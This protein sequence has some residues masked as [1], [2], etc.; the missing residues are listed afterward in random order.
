MPTIKQKKAFKKIIENHGSVSAAM[1]EVGY[2]EASAKNPSNLTESKGFKELMAQ[3]LPDG[4]LLK[5]HRKLLD[6]LDKEGEIDVQAVSKGLDMAYKLGG[7][8]SAEK[9]INI[10]VESEASPEI[11]ALADKL[12][13][14][15]RG[16]D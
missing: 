16:T 1:V 13:E 8:Y 10:N 11:K 2:T 14:L 7:N 3:E 15:H 12:N 4:Y 9:H 5:K 6:R